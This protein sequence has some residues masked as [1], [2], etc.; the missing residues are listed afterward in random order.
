VGSVVCFLS[1]MMSWYGVNF[2]LGQNGK[3]LHSYGLSTGGLG[4]AGGFA[5]FEI[6]F[7]A[8]VVWWNKRRPPSAKPPGPGSPVRDSEENL[9][10]QT[11]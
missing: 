11:A 5:V 8:F 7:V 10:S 3:S 6:L 1:V 4:Y 9:T 2:I